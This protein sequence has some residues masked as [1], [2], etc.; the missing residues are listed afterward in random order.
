MNI[1]LGT[2]VLAAGKGTRMHSD[3]PKVLQRM[4]GEPMLSYVLRELAPIAPSFLWTVIGHGADAVRSRFAHDETRFVEQKEQLGTGHALQTAWGELVAAGITH[5]LVVNGD[6]PLVCAETMRRFVDTALERN[7][8]LAFVTLTP[9]NAASFGRVVRANG[10]VRAIIEAKDFDEAVYGPCPRESNSGIYFVRCES[11]GPLLSLLRNTNKSGEYYITDLVEAAVAH[12]LVVEGVEAGNDMNLLGINSPA[13]LVAAEE[14]LRARLVDAALASGVLVHAP[15]QVRIG[16]DAVLEPGAEITGPCEIMGKSR[17]CRGAKVAS[18]CYMEDTL[19]RPGAVVQSF[20]H[21]VGAEIGEAC[22]IGPFARMRPGAVTEEGAHLG[23]F[24]EMKKS[25]LGKGAKANHLAYIGDATIGA[26]ANIGAGVITCNYD[27][28]K[29]HQT[30]IG[31]KAFVGSNVSLVAP[32][33]IGAN[34][35]IGA[36]STI[37]KDVPDN[38]LGIGR[39]RQV[40]FERKIK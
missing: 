38:F 33:S 10:K 39:A 31:E 6:T 21:L 37:T 8:D 25:V 18:H 22:F 7:C 16:P 12:N 4:L 11:I 26:G 27:G 13:E 35:L 32:V 17:I 40:A 19:I 34:A 14:M 30:L 5:A 15:A 29:K 23:S 1:R 20:C 24:V 9:D 28:K 36:G 2:V 3:A